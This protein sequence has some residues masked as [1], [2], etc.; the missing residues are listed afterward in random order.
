MDPRLVGFP[1]NEDPDKAPIIVTP[2][3]NPPLRPCCKLRR[4]LGES[5]GGA[6]G[7]GVGEGPGFENLSPSTLKGFRVQGLHAK[8]L[9]FWLP[10]DL[11]SYKAAFR[12]RPCKKPG[13]RSLGVSRKRGDYK[14]VAKRRG[15]LVSRPVFGGPL[16]K[17]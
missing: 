2:T 4:S 8:C 3:K 13:R 16:T 14:E 10:R 7:G 5:G 1:Y 15:T 6:G 12:R 9:K 17:L 11:H